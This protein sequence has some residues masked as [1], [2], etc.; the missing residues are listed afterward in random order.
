MS[1][2]QQKVHFTA[3]VA[4]SV[5]EANKLTVM[6]PLTCLLTADNQRQKK[7]DAQKETC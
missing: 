1:F 2:A 7:I 3:E 6:L 4:S 5:S